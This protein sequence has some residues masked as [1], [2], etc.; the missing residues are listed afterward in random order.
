[1]VEVWVLAMDRVYSRASW[2]ELRKLTLFEAMVRHNALT[3]SVAGEAPVF[4]LRCEKAFEDTNAAFYLPI[5]VGW[6]WGPFIQQCVMP[7]K[8]WLQERFTELWINRES[9]RLWVGGYPF[10]LKHIFH[11]VGLS[12]CFYC[13][14]T[15]FGSYTWRLALRIFGRQLYI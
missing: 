7:G 8:I 13:S 10:C 9:Y 5:F 1:M 15:V 3:T 4:L 14:L 11:D 12:R 6:L 2:N